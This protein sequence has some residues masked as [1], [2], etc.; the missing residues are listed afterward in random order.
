[1][2]ICNEKEQG[3]ENQGEGWEVGEEEDEEEVP[4]F[5]FLQELLN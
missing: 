5:Q 2:G 4:R 1:M 3:E